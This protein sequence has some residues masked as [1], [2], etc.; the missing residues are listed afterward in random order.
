MSYHNYE[1]KIAD[2]QEEIE[3]LEGKLDSARKVMLYYNRH[4][5]IHPMLED[6]ATQWLEINKEPN[7][8]N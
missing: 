7:E 5:G 1:M 4:S 8:E 2:L 3:R 6:F